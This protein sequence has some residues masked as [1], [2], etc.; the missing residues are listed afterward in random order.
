MSTVPTQ[1]LTAADLLPQTSI[2]LNVPQQGN[3]YVAPNSSYVPPLIYASPSASPSMQAQAPVFIPQISSSSQMSSSEFVPAVSVSPIRP[4]S[5]G[6]PPSPMNM[7]MQGMQMPTMVQVPS[8][9]MLDP[10]V[11]DPS[12]ASMMQTPTFVF[13]PP[14]RSVSPQP[15]HPSL[16]ND[17]AS[18][19]SNYSCNSVSSVNGAYE[20]SKYAR[21]DY[22]R[23]RSSSNERARSNSATQR[24]PKYPW[25]SKQNKIDVVHG[26][27]KKRFQTN[28]LWTEEQLRGPDT[29]RTHVKTFQG[30]VRIHHALDR[31]LGSGVEIL[32][33]AAP[34]SMKNK[35]QKKGFIVYIKLAQQ[36]HVQTVMNIFKDSEWDGHFN[37]T[38]V[39]LTV[40]EKRARENVH[41]TTMMAA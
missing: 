36:E 35:W 39:A 30:L 37:K 15:V 16:E 13:F 5:F 21:G 19:H 12:M 27:V 1:Q 17:N 10:M 11:Y 32:Q 28:Q 24:G 40:E 20:E 6:Y 8:L 38:D 18:Y 9:P 4:M 3:S 14:S 31:V 22:E 34:I 7:G 23:A 26:E 2:H 33:F 29:V 41:M 25:R